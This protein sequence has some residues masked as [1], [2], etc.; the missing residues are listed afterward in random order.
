[1]SGNVANLSVIYPFST[2]GEYTSGD[3]HLYAPINYGR[4]Y[5]TDPLDITSE[6]K[7]NRDID[8]FLC[9]DATRVN[10]LTFQGQGGFAMVLDPEGQIKT[11]SPY[12]QVCASFS[13][14]NNY[15]RF[16]GGQFV[17]GFAGR[18]KGVITDIEDS[19]LTV[20]VTGYP[21]SGL[22]V[23]AP[24][25]PCAFYV[26]GYRY[27]INDIISYD[28]ST[29]TVVLR[30][31]V[32]TPYDAA[33]FY[34]NVTCSRDVGLIL[35]AVTYDMTVGSNFQAVRAGLS[36]LRADAA[37]VVGVQQTQTVSGINKSA[38]LAATYTANPTA[39]ASLTT[40]YDIINT[41]ITQ[42]DTAA[43][44]ITYTS[45][46]NSTTDAVKLKDNLQANRTFVRDEIVAW[47]SAN[48]ITNQIPNYSAVKCSRD[49]GYLID[50][51]CYD[52]MYGGNSMTFDAMLSYYGRSVSS[53]T[54]AGSQIAG[55][56]AVTQAAYARMKVV[57]QQI[58]TNT[59]VTKS[60]GNL[61]VQTV[62]A[63][64]S[65]GSGTTEYSTLGTL[66]DLITDYVIDG[67]TGTA[68][69]TP[70]L[71]GLDS[72]LLTARSAIVGA[73]STIQNGTITY[74]NTGGGQTINI[75][76][77]GNKSML[78]NDF[79]MINDLGYAIV[80][81]NGGVTEQVSTFSYYCYT[82]YWAADGG[83]IRSVAG[84]NSYGVY[85]LRAT[86][87]DVTEK[88]DS[89]TL[90]Q[91][92]MQVAR[93]YKQGAFASAMTPTPTQQAI[94]VYI[95]GYSYI[96][97][98]ISEL[99]ID[100]T[101]AGLGI[102]RYEVNSVAHTAVTV[103][104]QN[105][106][107]LN[108]S[109]AGNN[110]TS[111]TGL[112]TTLYDGQQILIR[113]LQNIK[114]LGV[115]NVKPT[116]PSTAVQYNDNLA[117]IYRVIA[118]N[119]VEASGEQLGSNIAILSTDQSFSYYKFTTDPAKIGQVDRDVAIEVTATSGTGTVATLT[120][121]NQGSAPYTIGS[122][123][124]VQDLL[125]TGY[126][127]TYVVTGCTAT[128]VS[129]DNTTTGSMT[130]EGLVSDRAQGLFV[131]DNKI[132]VLQ[133]S[134]QTTVD[135]VNKG[136]YIT[137]WNGR[138]HR[139]T[140][141]TV[142]TFAATATY[143]TGGTAS[144]TMF[145]ST[146]AGTIYAGQVL[147]GTG[148]TSDQY[149]VSF[150]EGSPNSTVVISAVADS[151][152]SGT[153]TFGVNRNGWLN[154]DPN[155]VVNIVGDGSSIPALSYVSKSVPATGLKF[156][157][158]DV[159]WT[160]SNLP[161]VDSYVYISGQST[162]GYNGTRQI[163]GRVSQT[164]ITVPSTSSLSVG[165]VVSSSSP[166]A[167]V[168]SGTII[169]SIDS[170]TEFTVS[171]ACW[172]PAG[173]SVSSTIVAVLSGVTITDSGSGYTSAPLLTVQGGGAVSPAIISC[174]IA[175]GSISTVTVVSPGYGYTS[176]PTI[177]VAEGNAVLTA[178]LSASATVS[179]TA[180]AGVN[181]NQITVAY[182]A[183][184]GV[185]TA[186]TSITITGFTSKNGPAEFEGSITG[187]TLT[188]S[189]VTSGTIAIG[190]QISGTGIAAGTY[191]TAG[192][193]LS[194]TVSESQNATTTTITSDYAVAL[195]FASTTAPTVGSYFEVAGNTN[196]LYNGIYRCTASS[197]TSITMSYAYDPGTWSTA[198][199]TT[200]TE[201]IVSATSNSLGISKPFSTTGA[202]TLRLGRAK[203]SR[204]QITTRIST[205]RVTGHDLLDIGTGGYSTTNY[206]YQI[207]GNPA[208][209]A[210]QTQE[211][212]EEGVGR[213]FYV[214]TDQN[215]IFRV[216]RY[217]TVDQGTGTVTFSASI[218]LSNLD[219]LGFKRGVVVSQFSTDSAMTENA[220]D[221]VPVQSAIRSYIDK[222]LG[223]DYG[224]GPVTIERLIGYEGRPKHGQ[225]QDW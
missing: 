158:Y 163:T 161:I 189:S 203:N 82:H 53:E 218:A 65:I 141:Y 144:T 205:C 168:P 60:A 41:I 88:P 46:V 45:N 6:P 108:L 18:L 99:E 195:A 71:T 110:G 143:V 160:P 91:D 198:T 159:A 138:V 117:E 52:I 194:W 176:T 153:I 79:A 86:G 90:A 118:Y 123:I 102:V 104:G 142:P 199:T 172:V 212:Y 101:V 125:P 38:E 63:A 171:P 175:G 10:N 196:P 121:A 165:M 3:W 81:K 83:Q 162:S 9:N 72:G 27:Q 89:V 185:W 132:A 25:P 59:T 15:K 94:S 119:L 103:N 26:Q 207:Y 181:T 170:V 191:I 150:T 5:L 39:L 190:Q 1:V 69:A 115:D 21:N 40:S 109:T 22:D 57:L 182:D 206:P 130:Q 216:G 215:G 186:Q 96:P 122:S 178:I 164:Q 167:Y 93:V 87:Y 134:T 120:F 16:A 34:N 145:V 208:L 105:V 61:S 193:G 36:Y 113:N 179:T 97:Y 80:A 210:T 49:V 8:V 220:P 217:F 14:S 55:E 149:V 200:V 76:M 147:T 100:H 33:S 42:G 92:M 75:E 58:V 7:N 140:S 151:T 139:I 111:S 223:I 155:P 157:T 31:D 47:I 126:N 137:S 221:I 135:Q 51:L 169:S 209:P 177:L 62:N 13:Q 107:Q 35:D 183:D 28:Q 2:S 154:I 224:G 77:G 187:T 180:S 225:L 148:F 32:A 85:A 37:L 211:I 213:V 133:V 50:S 67:A 124:V 68:R 202:I 204:A 74:L 106:L 54:G 44:A 23:R 95:L 66:C 12:G 56:E 20:T 116:R 222:R 128:S 174:T 4:F 73:K 197:A 219:G 184:P 29:A 127:G 19:G 173:A 30:M 201:E 188:V 17:D 114:F 166:G 156:V 146:V 152:P 70:S 192:A 48:Y 78:A 98:N 214:T 24:L 131:N 11:K 43:P 112:A 129:Y 64:Y 136:T 84:S